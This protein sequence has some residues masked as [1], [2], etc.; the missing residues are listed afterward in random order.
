MPP[1]FDIENLRCSYEHPFISGTSKVVLEIKRLEIP[2]GTMVFI[3]GESGIGK[4]TVLEAL[5]MMNRTMVPDPEAKAC[6]IDKDGSRTDLVALWKDEAR[7]TEFRLKH[8]SFIF[9]N[10]NLMRNF[11]AFENVA[12]T[13]LLQGYSR[14]ETMG[15]VKRLLTELGL[16]SVSE[17][18]SP[19]DLSGGQQQR[20]AFA[21]AT[22][23]DFSVLF[24]DEP[25]GNLDSGNAFRAMALLEHQ[26][27]RHEG[28]SS[29]IVTHDMPLA[30]RYAGMIVK[31]RRKNGIGYVDE[32]CVFRPDR[33]RETWSNGRLT[34]QPC[35]FEMFLHQKG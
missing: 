25:T 7:L 16:G 5:G 9:Q 14:E 26:L 12:I 29:V 1:L 18:D 20:L 10:T 35:E 34:F 23:P 33:E 6:F 30:V 15:K 32:T 13:R 24:G 28:R 19:Q 4:S 8:F 2:R 22:L 17:S 3:V 31:M 27:E 11:T 21:R